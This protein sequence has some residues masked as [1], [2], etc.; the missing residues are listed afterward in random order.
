M[1]GFPPFLGLMAAIEEFVAVPC[2]RFLEGELVRHQHC[3]LWFHQETWL[4]ANLVVNIVWKGKRKVEAKHRHGIKNAEYGDATKEEMRKT[5]DDSVYWKEDTSDPLWR[6][7]KGWWMDSTKTRWQMKWN[8]CRKNLRTH[9]TTNQLWISRWILLQQVNKIL[10][11][12]HI[13]R[14]IFTPNQK[15]NWPPPAKFRHKCPTATFSSVC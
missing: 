5:S 6:P 14:K 13:A 10:Q 3:Q 12:M 7:P 1:L 9:V 4:R 8:V 2:E 15:V 11:R